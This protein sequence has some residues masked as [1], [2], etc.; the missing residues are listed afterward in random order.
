MCSRCLELLAHLAETSDTAA[1]CSGS[2]GANQGVREY[3]CTL[4][5]HL[6]QYVCATCDSAVA[7]LAVPDAD[8]STLEGLLTAEYAVELKIIIE[9]PEETPQAYLH[10]YLGVLG[11][12]DL[13]HELTQRSTISRAV[14]TADADLLCALSLSRI[15]APELVFKWVAHTIST[16]K[17]GN[18][19]EWP[20]YKLRKEVRR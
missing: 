5:S 4:K 2:R 6:R 13:L 1:S 20:P 14:F 8:G 7:W 3:L 9:S 10:S 18:R 17:H 16:V 11:D 19:V 15:Q 12:L